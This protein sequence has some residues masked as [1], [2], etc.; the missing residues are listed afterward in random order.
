MVEY[1]Q[2]RT[3]YFDDFGGEE[4][5]LAWR[6]EASRKLNGVINA[7]EV[8]WSEE[9]T[10]EVA[11]LTT[12]VEDPLVTVSSVVLL[13]PTT[14]NAANILPQCHLTDPDFVPGSDFGA[15]GGQFTINHP[16]PLPA[17]CRYRYA[18]LG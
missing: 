2:T 10:L 15:A 13:M 11:S 14:L 12:V 5:Q 17:D 8:C 9:L 16:N 3:T 18:I 6:R 4:H 7:A 1:R